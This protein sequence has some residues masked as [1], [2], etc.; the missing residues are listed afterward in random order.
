M[1]DTFNLIYRK[2][3]KAKKKSQLS[4]SKTSKRAKSYSP[5]INRKISRKIHHILD[6]SI[7]KNKKRKNICGCKN[8]ILNKTFRSLTTSI[9]KEKDKRRRSA[10]YMLELQK[11]KKSLKINI[12]NKCI[13]AFS[14]KAKKA[15]INNIKIKTKLNPKKIIPPKQLLGNCWFNVF[16]VMMFISDK[17]MKFFKFFRYLMIMGETAN[18]IKIPFKIHMAFIILNIAIENAYNLHSSC[19]SMAKTNDT[20]HIIFYL[21]HAIESMKNPKELIEDSNIPNIHDAGNPYMYYKG[22]MDF[23]SIQEVNMIKVNGAD[24]INNI[25]LSELDSYSFIPH[26]IVVEYSS[27]SISS[28]KQTTISIPFQERDITYNLDSACIIDNNQEH[29]CCTL[30]ING[31]EYGF[32]GGSHKR[33]EAFNWVKLLNQNKDWTFKGTNDDVSISNEYKWNFMNG[34]SMLFY[35]LT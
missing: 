25:V 27:H 2:T 12:N 15:M 19:K 26:I 32:E 8:K 35:Y 1:Y 21:K 20:N 7:N 4:H 9:A 23:L 3:K 28:Q 29:F 6:L 22:I 30:H 33:L 11:L 13:S 10:N 18:G 14:S 17:G 34:Y 24:D 16:F 31:K 5:S